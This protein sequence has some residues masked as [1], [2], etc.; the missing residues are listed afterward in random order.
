[1]MAKASLAFS[2]PEKSLIGSFTL[3]PLKLNPPRYVLICFS[4]IFS[5]IFCICWKAD[6][7]R[8]KSSTWCCEKYPTLKFTPFSRLPASI[9][10]LPTKLLIKVDLPAPLGPSKPIRSPGD[11]VILISLLYPSDASSSLTNGLDI[12]LVS[13]IVN[14]KG[15]SMCAG[16]ISSIFSRAFTLLWAC[17]AFVALALNLLIKLCICSTSF[18]CLIKLLCISAILSALIISNCE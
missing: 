11:I 14:L 15:E 12:L 4:L 7:D 6:I 9:G 13:G 1:M 10:K 2:P 8:S 16:A 5:S 18:C 3:S 17:F